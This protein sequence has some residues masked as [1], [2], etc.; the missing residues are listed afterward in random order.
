MCS[1]GK[2][3][4]QQVMEGVGH[5]AN[6]TSR[7]SKTTGY[8]RGEVIKAQAKLDKIKAELREIEMSGAADGE[9]MDKITKRLNKAKKELELAELTSLSS[10]AGMAGK[11]A[12]N[13]GNAKQAVNI[14]KTAADWWT[15]L[16][17]STAAAKAGGAL[18]WKGVNLA[19]YV[20][21]VKNN[22]NKAQKPAQDLWKNLC[23]LLAECELDEDDRSND[24]IKSQRVLNI[25]A[26]Y[27]RP[28]DDPRKINMNDVLESPAATGHP[29]A[30][31]IREFLRQQRQGGPQPAGEPE[32][33]IEDK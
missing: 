27:A 5:L 19:Y 11:A 1:F 28:D 33:L 17:P 20:Q 30:G 2:G 31:V 6:A 15:S 13:Y 3:F 29:G 7:F 18:A 25:F 4:D 22:D 24:I 14:A 23:L 12:G 8:G 21:K 10:V 16:N 32:S 9:E 26:D